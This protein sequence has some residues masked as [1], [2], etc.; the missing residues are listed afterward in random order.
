MT[1]TRGADPG[2]RARSPAGPCPR[3]LTRP[4]LVRFVSVAGTSLSFYLLLAT[5]PLYARAGG[6]SPGTAGLTTT[7]L[8]AA[9]VISYLAAPAVAARFGY[10]PMLAAGLLALGLPALA[11][12]ARGGLALIMAACVLRG[13]GFAMLC[14]AGG[15]LTVSLIPA[16]RR[17]EGLALVGAVSG[18]GSVTAL[19]AGVWLAGHVGYGPVFVAGG[20]AAL[21][22]LASIPWLPAGPTPAGPTRAGPT[23]AGTRP[24]RTGPARREPADSLLTTL[25][26]PGLVRPAIAFAATT[27]A[28]GVF[29]TFLP[30]AL[31]RT[32]PD[33]V[34]LSLLAQPAAAIAGRWLAGWIGDRRG[35]AALLGPGM[36]AAAAGL[37]LLGLD[38]TPALVVTGAAVFGAGFG[39]AQNVTQTLMYDRVPESGFSPVSA[40]W[41]LAYDGGMGLGTAGFGLL[42]TRTGYPAA[43]ALTAVMLPVVL[44]A[45]HAARPFGFFTHRAERPH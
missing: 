11:L 15:A 3:L 10:R 14:V 13:L 16:Q 5:V 21:I 29:V 43:F 17:G 24:A 9:T 40:L 31:A 41:N 23:P 30:L 34:A 6:A 18:I 36:L 26:R 39:V 22:G 33:V 44:A 8:T 4:L 28:V 7:A 19:P 38:H 1:S 27:M 2:V 35:P 37:A 45:G 20:L 32:A 42:V 12:A 25:R